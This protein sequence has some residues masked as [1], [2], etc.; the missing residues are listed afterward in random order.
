[1]TDTDK[2]LSLFHYGRKML[3]THAPDDHTLNENVIIIFQSRRTMKLS[4]LIFLAIA[5]AFSYGQDPS[6]NGTTTRRKRKKK[7]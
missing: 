3:V 1:V 5:T 4:T 7:F 6:S 2:H